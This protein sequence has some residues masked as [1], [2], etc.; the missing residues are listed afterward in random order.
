[1]TSPRNGISPT[2]V[3][4]MD[5]P[6]SGRRQYR[7]RYGVAIRKFAIGNGYGEG[8]HLL[9]VDGQAAG[10]IEAKKEGATLIGVEIQ[11]PI[12]ARRARESDRFHALTYDE[13][14]NRDKACLD[15]FWL[16]A[17]CFR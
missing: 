2:C 4:R 9:F 1:M 11:T 15:I 10:V 3:R 17:S 16:V 7:R 14:V 13:L 6:E 5:C 12:I 8:D